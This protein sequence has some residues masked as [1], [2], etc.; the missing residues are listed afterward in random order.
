MI[1]R[2]SSALTKQSISPKKF[3][4][5]E[6]GAFVNGISTGAWR[7]CRVRRDRRRYPMSFVD[8][9]LHTRYSDGS[10]TPAELC[11]LR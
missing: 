8:L 5:R 7:T 2:Q 1:F 11:A 6:S 4:T 9:H 10:W 3:S